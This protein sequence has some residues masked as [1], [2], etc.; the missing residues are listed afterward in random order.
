MAET[1]ERRKIEIDPAAM[2]EGYPCAKCEQT[3]NGRPCVR[4]KVFY[5]E[6]MHKCRVATGCETPTRERQ[7]RKYVETQTMIARFGDEDATTSREERG[8]M[9]QEKIKAS[10]LTYRAVA[11]RMNLSQ[12]TIWSYMR[13][14]VSEKTAALAIAAVEALLREKKEE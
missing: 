2:P 4:F 3:C 13:D 7:Y 14:G 1:K 12:S 5:A 9:L 8:R 10:G 11:E 6:F